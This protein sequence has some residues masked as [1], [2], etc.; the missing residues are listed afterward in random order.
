M[1]SGYS[2]RMR[3][4]V[5]HPRERAEAGA[6]TAAGTP[7]A[8][9]W[10]GWLRAVTLAV[11][12]P[13]SALPYWADLLEG[14]VGDGAVELGSGTVLRAER[15]DPGFASGGLELADPDARSRANDTGGLTDPDDR[16]FELFEMPAP[17]RRAE[18]AGPRLG[19]L[20]FESPDPLAA[21]AWWE[22]LGFRLSE[23]LGGFFRWLRCN[24]IHHTVAFSRSDAPRLHHVGIEVA[25]RAALIDH[26][27]RLA[28]LGHPIQYG[29]GRHFV[30]GNL[31]IYFLDRHGIR[32]EIFCELERIDDPDRSGPVH[33]DELSREGSVNTWGPQPPEA[34]FRGI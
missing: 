26:C 33:G 32:F 16:R 22:D 24:P 3:D 20:T 34:F 8:P 30:G 7:Q 29:P 11:P 19:H 17:G 15:G 31:F 12:D 9:R 4:D 14:Q 21:Q 27:D 6:T 5:Q 25:D 2:S 10:T 23:G 28:E 18:P 13:D 1:G